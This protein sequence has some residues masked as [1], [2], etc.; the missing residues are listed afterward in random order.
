VRPDGHR[1]ITPACDDAFREVVS[2]SP[3]VLPAWLSGAGLRRVAERVGV[4]RRTARRYVE[5]AQAAGLVRDG[6]EDQL[7]PGPIGQVVEAVRPARHG[8]DGP[9]WQALEAEHG[10]IRQGRRRFSW[11]ASCLRCITARSTRSSH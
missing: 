2:E 7:P 9:T 4:D 6:G 3:E 1:L 5:A 11:A 8:G 10:Q